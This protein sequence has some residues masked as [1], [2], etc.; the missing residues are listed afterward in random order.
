MSIL[1]GV[2]RNPIT[3]LL[4]NFVEPFLLLAELRLQR[5]DKGQRVIVLSLRLGALNSKLILKF[6]KSPFV[7][8]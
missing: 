1:S 4:S 5:C 8:G 6:A 2:L 7:I 3:F